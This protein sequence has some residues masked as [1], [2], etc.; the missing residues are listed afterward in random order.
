MN[1]TRAEKQAAY[2]RANRERMREANRR[3]RAANPEK[4]AVLQARAMAR[5]KADPEKRKRDDAKWRAKNVEKTRASQAK[6]AAANRDKVKA[7]TRRWMER[8]VEKMQ[9]ARLRWEANNPER[10]AVHRENRRARER[11]AIGQ[12]STDIV[13]KLMLAQKGKCPVC[14][15]A[16]GNRYDIDHKMPLILGGTNDDSNIQLLCRTCNRSKGKKHPDVFMRERGF[17]L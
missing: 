15:C 17:L 14:R 8:N 9:A 16:L 2:Y 10:K 6:Y 3:W 1:L 7:A 12:M 13:Q 4:L 5:R 11:D